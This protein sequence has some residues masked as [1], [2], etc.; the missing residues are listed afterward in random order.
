[1]SFL[2]NLFRRGSRVPSDRAATA[3]LEP[4]V[5]L[6]QPLEVKRQHVSVGAAHSAG[7]ERSRDDDAL[8]VLTGGADGHDGFLDFGLFCVADGLGGYELGNVASAVAV[9]ALASR[10]TQGAFL[11]L[12]ELNPNDEDFALEDLVRQ[13]FEDANHAVVKRAKGGAT[14]LTAALLLGERLMIGHVGD[15]RAYFINEDEMEMLTRDQ[16]LVRELV[17]TGA[18]SEDEA[19][20]SP[21]RNV[22]WNAIGKSD[23]VKVDVFSRSVMHD[24]YLLICSDGLWGEVPDRELK[25]IV[26]SETDPQ[27]ACEILVQ[28]AN[29]AGGADN[30]TAVLVRFPPKQDQV[31]T[32]VSRPK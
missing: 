26:N 17:D 15:T 16:S 2:K 32:G 31:K 18:M 24:G 7:M 4:F 19:L 6:D 20:D 12:F 14:T 9:R 28:T 25:R 11:R 29:E 22:L 13:A 5:G 23:E 8:L 10:L 1:M 27:K 3:P 30:I 21:H